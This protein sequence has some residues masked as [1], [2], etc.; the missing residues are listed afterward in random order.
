MSEKISRSDFIKSLAAVFTVAWT[1]VASY[2]VF[3][4]LISGGRKQSQ[5][6]ENI[7][8]LSLG[9]VDDFLPGSSKNF[10]FGSSPALL[11]RS[12]DG[13]FHAYN[14][15][16]THLGCTVQYSGEKKKIW[17]A[18]H[19]G[20]FDAMTGKNLSGPP[21]KPLKTLNVAVVDGEIIVS[22]A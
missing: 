5:G 19:G 4:Y 16:C 9:K 14:A 1:G 22:R 8:S 12:D 17:C 6:K 13:S 15:I 20:T 21:P 18:C 3:R 7:S 10:K 2:P 11:I